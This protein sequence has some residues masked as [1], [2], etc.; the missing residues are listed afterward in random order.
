MPIRRRDVLM[1]RL[2]VKL[3]LLAL[4][5]VVGTHA[6]A[7]EVAQPVTSDAAEVTDCYAYRDSPHH[8]TLAVVLFDAHSCYESPAEQEEWREVGAHCE[9]A[10]ERHGEAAAIAWW[11]KCKEWLAR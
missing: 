11:S 7:E 3:A 2:V 4:A 9:P 5:V 10:I 1:V 8:A 6:V